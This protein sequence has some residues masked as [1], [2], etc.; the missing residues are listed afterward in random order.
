MKGSL[1][2]FP[3]LLAFASPAINA[4][5][6]DPYRR[7]SLVGHY[8][9]LDHDLHDWSGWR[10]EFSNNARRRSGVYGALVEERRFGEVDTGIE[11]GAA[12]AFGDGW[13]FQPEV[14]IAP[15]SHFLPRNS[16]DLRLGRELGNGW[17]A[18]GSVGRRH[19]RDAD[20]DRAGVGVER[21]F[22]AWRASYQLNL[23]RLHGRDSAGHDLRLARA[24]GDRSEV[25]V[26][27]AFGQEPTELG[28]RVVTT[29]VRAFGI[30]G[31][32]AFDPHWALLWNAGSVRQGDFYTR[33]GIV[34]GVERRF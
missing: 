8:D 17:V 19:Y 20:V 7:V 12:L 24:Y 16:L 5:V 34:V 32:H 29:N 11:A 22:G 31:R 18:S 30:F 9:A 26:Q 1:A 4:Q 28:A 14:S 27:A 2:V 3:L 15:G 33:R 10:L 21:Y 13:T 25:G 23:A 6:A